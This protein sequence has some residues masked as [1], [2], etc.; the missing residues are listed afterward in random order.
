MAN[1][2]TLSPWC[3][4]LGSR[5]CYLEQVVPSD[6]HLCVPK[7]SW[8]SVFL[9]NCLLCVHWTSGTSESR[10]GLLLG[11]L[12]YIWNVMHRLVVAKHISWVSYMA[13]QKGGPIWERETIYRIKIHRHM[14]KQIGHTLNPLISSLVEILLFLKRNFYLFILVLIYCPGIMPQWVKLLSPTSASRIGVLVRVLAVPLW[15]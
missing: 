9:R 1:C 11:R 5:V 14:N 13:G 2:W 8:G 7:L 15:L 6:I 4:S 10:L 3:C 12:G